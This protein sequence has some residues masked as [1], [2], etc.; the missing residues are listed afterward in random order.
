MKRTPSLNRR[1]QLETLED[2]LVP[3]IR[4]V[5]VGSL[6][7]ITGSRVAD[8]IRLFDNGNGTISVV[9]E[10]DPNARF[11]TGIT[12][13]V[14]NTRDG[15]DRLRYELSSPATFSPLR[16]FANLGR[17]RDTFNGFLN[18]ADLF[19]GGSRTFDIRGQQGSDTM[20]MDAATFATDVFQGAELNVVFNGGSPPPFT[21]IDGN[22]LMIF[23]YIGLLDGSLAYVA[24]GG[25][26]VF[27]DTL[28]GNIITT[29]GSD[30]RIF[31]REFGRQGRD[32][33]T[34]FI[35]VQRPVSI[36]QP[37]VVFLDALIDGGPGLDRCRKTPNVTAV[38]CELT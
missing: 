17:D 9:N 18:G 6:L 14:V 21:G 38:N 34:L 15:N 32:D 10:P 16:L 5:Q 37:S 28:F 27:S 26:S 25:V 8:R 11:F 30:G 22:D 7:T 33:L 19:F 36:G 1:P 24:D 12:E 23:E 31:A 20:T 4:I 3:A 35:E 29:P 2:R 13:V